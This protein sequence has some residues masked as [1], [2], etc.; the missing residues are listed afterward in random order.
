MYQSKNGFEPS[1]FKCQLE[2]AKHGRK[3]KASSE[4]DYKK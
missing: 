1:Y 2:T 4:V 3:Q